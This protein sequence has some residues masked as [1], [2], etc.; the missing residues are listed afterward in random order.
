MRGSKTHLMLPALGLVMLSAAVSAANF[1]RWGSGFGQGVLEYGI[2]NDSA[3]SDRIYIACSDDWGTSISFTVGGKNPP[4]RSDVFVAAGR[5]QLELMTDE[6]G[7]FRTGSHVASDTFRYLW[8]MM[9]RENVLHVRLSSGEST[10][11]TLNGAAKVL[12]RDPCKTD[13]ER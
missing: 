7:S 6:N 11:F 3:G 9:R 12:P 13:F 5:D 1:G 10:S 2:Q 4:A 8:T